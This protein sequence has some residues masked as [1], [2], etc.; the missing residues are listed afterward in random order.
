MAGVFDD[1]I[2]TAIE[3]IEEFGQH[4]F[5]R[6]PAPIVEAE[7][8]YPEEGDTP[9]P[10]PCTLAFFSAKDLDR[11]VQDYLSAMPGTEVPDNAQVG[12]MAGGLSF[13]PETVDMISRGSA[14]A[15]PISIISLDILAPN[16]TPIL[17]FVRVAA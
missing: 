11:G 13:T 17:Y 14:D 4:C 15:D 8:G 7:P 9:D 3:L 2:A 16:G 5:W 10:I 6:K 12:L 1:D